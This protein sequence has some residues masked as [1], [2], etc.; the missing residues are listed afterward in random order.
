MEILKRSMAPITERAWAEID[1]AVRRTLVARLCGRKVVDVKG[2]LGLEAA[3]VNLGRLEL[4]SQPKNA[5]VRYG[6]RRVQP[7]VEGRAN[8]DLDIW[9]LD[10]VER[11]DPAIDVDAAEQA[12]RTMASFE[13]TA[14]FNGFKPGGIVGLTQLDGHKPVP[15]KLDAKALLDALARAVIA[16]NDAAVDGPYDLV[17]GPDVFRMLSS[18]QSPGYPLGKQ[19]AGL[20]GGRVLYS[21]VLDG[22]LLV[23]VRGGDFELTLGQDLAVGYDSRDA[24]KVTLFVTES[25]TF[26]VL[27][28]AGCLHLPLKGAK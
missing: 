5:E 18:A 17:T 9:G 3:A 7:L 12:A 2:P 15:L 4:P 13:D 24:R 14:I 16:M 1:D 6:I 10:D 8:F 25:F 20:I 26:R 19:V 27:D 11:G 21:T 22:A 28:P 23:S